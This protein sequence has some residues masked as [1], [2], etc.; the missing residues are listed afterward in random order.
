MERL[1]DSRP[2]IISKPLHMRRSEKIWGLFL[3]RTTPVYDSSTVMSEPIPKIVKQ[4]ERE[5]RIA[6]RMDDDARILEAAQ[7]RNRAMRRSAAFRRDVD[8]IEQQVEAR[9]RR[10]EKK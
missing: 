2:R 7:K 10:R 1:S 6:K 4:K 9:R 3:A 5:Q 8:F